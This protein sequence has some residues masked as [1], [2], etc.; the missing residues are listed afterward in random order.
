MDQVIFDKNNQKPLYRQ[1][2]DEIRR[3]IKDGE[4]LPGQKLM[5]E[6]EMLKEYGVGKSELSVKIPST[7]KDRVD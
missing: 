4:I 1:L 2:A 6:S 7:N 3:Q 5:S